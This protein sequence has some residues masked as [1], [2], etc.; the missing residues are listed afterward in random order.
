MPNAPQ[1]LQANEI[2][3]LAIIVRILKP[4]QNVTELKAEK[5]VT[6]S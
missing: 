2:V 3:V 1:M 6:A 4:N 5:Y